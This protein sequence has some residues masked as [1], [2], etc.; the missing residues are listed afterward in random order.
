V[1]P[2]VGS[3]LDP[4]YADATLDCVWCANVTQYVT[5]TEFSRVVGEFRHVVKPGGL[6]AV[7][8]TDG[9]ILHLLPLDPAI[10]AR[11]VPAGVPK[12]PR[13]GCWVPDADR[14]WPAS[15]ARRG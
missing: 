2:R 5:E 3:V 13:Q 6:V 12:R 15:S 9:T 4:P 11:E 14:R 10:M 7:M 8:D 1:E